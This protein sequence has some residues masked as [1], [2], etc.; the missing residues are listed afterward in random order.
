MSTYNTTVIKTGNSY[1]LR[2]PKQYVTDANLR[3]GQKVSITLPVVEAVQNRSRIQ[4]L[5]LELQSI[6]AYKE[7]ADPVIWQKNIRMDRAL[8]EREV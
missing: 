1:A 8:P 3:L 6:A 7:I 2:V 4:S 5:L